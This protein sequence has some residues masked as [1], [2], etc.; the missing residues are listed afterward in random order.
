VNRQRSQR[1]RAIDIKWK[2][3][4]GSEIRPTH[5]SV[6]ARFRNRSFVGALMDVAFRR[7]K[8]MTRFPKKAARER[9]MF[10]QEMAKLE[11]AEKSAVSIT[12][13]TRGHV[14]C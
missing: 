14:E 6:R 10:I 2:L 12:L 9:G 5:K 7:A 8:K 3:N 13:F 4:R 1:F 11:L